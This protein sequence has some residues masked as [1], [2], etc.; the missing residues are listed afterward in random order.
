MEEETFN[1]LNTTM[2]NKELLSYDIAPFPS[3]IKVGN[4]E[5]IYVGKESDLY[6]CNFEKIQ[7][8]SGYIEK[9]NLLELSSAYIE[10][11]KG[12]NLEWLNDCKFLKFLHIQRVSGDYS[13]LN[14]LK[15]LKNVTKFEITDAH[16]L[17]NPD[18]EEIVDKNSFFTDKD[19]QCLKNFPSIDN[20]W[21]HCNI[22]L[23]GLTAL[24]HLIQNDFSTTCL[25]VSSHLYQSL[26]YTGIELKWSHGVNDTEDRLCISSDS[27]ATKTNPKTEDKEAFQ[28]ELLAFLSN[29]SKGNNKK[30]LEVRFED[31]YLQEQSY[32]TLDSFNL[33]VSESMQFDYDYFEIFYPHNYNT[34]K[35]TF[36]F[37]RQFPHLKEFHYPSIRTDII[38]NVGNNT[39]IYFG[40]RTNEYAGCLDEELFYQLVKSNKKIKIHGQGVDT[41]LLGRFTYE[42]IVYLYEKG[43]IDCNQQM[44][45]KIKEL[46]LKLDAIIEQ[47]NFDETVSDFEKFDAIVK[48][49]CNN[50]SYSFPDEEL[51]NQYGWLYVA[52]DNS[53]KGVC[54]N[55]AV[56]VDA[57]AKRLELE[58]YMVPSN[59]KKHVWNIICLDKMY[60]Y[61]DL[62]WYDYDYEKGDFSKEWYL[63]PAN[64]QYYF[65]PNDDHYIKMSSILPYEFQQ[66]QLEPIYLVE[67]SSHYYKKRL[68]SMAM[69]G[70]T[71]GYLFMDYFL[72]FQNRKNKDYDLKEKQKIKG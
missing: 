10:L 48:Y 43:F 47:F 51:E 72:L 24:N 42:E 26:T 45:E 64:L 27:D 55:Y 32:F 3:E 60:Y 6:L 66:Y 52:L 2:K 28:L 36:C 54:R 18:V 13:A 1:V 7:K 71:L 37:L 44:L 25:T 19:V 17:Y 63:T 69:N 22:D 8:Q 57:L 58:C 33:A 68:F 61:T 39:E 12:M 15:E 9:S 38:E 29:F 11:T 20:I 40:N 62:T 67:S 23:K 30:I 56:L 65:Y 21:I 53:G 34:S 41:N 50:I 46:D 4:K 35:N 16:V 5:F 70:G 31:S 14:Q 59:N 49:V